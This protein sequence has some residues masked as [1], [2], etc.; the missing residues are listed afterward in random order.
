M[1]LRHVLA[2]LAAELLA[3]DYVLVPIQLG[4]PC[5]VGSDGL[6]TALER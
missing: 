4:V 2:V 6:G 3:W 5:L 1:C